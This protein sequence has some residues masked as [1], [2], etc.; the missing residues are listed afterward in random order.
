MNSGQTI[1]LF[2]GSFNPA[3]LGHMHVAECGLQRLRLDQIWWMVSPQNPLKPTQPP[4]KQRVDTVRALNLPHRMKISHM[5]RDFGTHYTVDTL[6]RAKIRWPHHHFVFLMGA[7]NL[8][9]LPKWKG[10][11]EIMETVPL[12]VIARTGTRNGQ[13]TTELL[14]ARLSQAAQNYAYARIPESQAHTLARHAAP[15]WTYLTPP[16]NPLSSSAIRAKNTP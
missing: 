11:R 14:K 1:G 3:H 9:Q 15:A 10:W 6:R 4:Y 8:R 5:E 7:D 12:A 16:L 13:R 2:G